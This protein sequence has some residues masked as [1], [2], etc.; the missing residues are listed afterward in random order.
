[1]R[2]RR[3]ERRRGWAELR[4]SSG[5]VCVSRGL[6]R[7]WPPAGSHAGT[8]ATLTC[9]C[10][11]P[12]LSRGRLTGVQQAGLGRGGSVARAARIFER[13]GRA[14]GHAARRTPATTA[15]V[16]T[17][18]PRAPYEG[19]FRAERG[20]GGPGKRPEN[21]K[22]A[23][24]QKKKRAHAV[25]CVAPRPGA[26]RLNRSPF[27]RQ[28]C[29]VTAPAR[30]G[31]VTRTRRRPGHHHQHTQLTRRVLLQACVP[32][33]RHQVAQLLEL[34]RLGPA[35]AHGGESACRALTVFFLRRVVRP[36][37]LSLFIHHSRPPATRPFPPP[38]PS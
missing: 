30:S 22:G 3:R 5:R 9:H 38:A 8:A 21:V 31:R 4:R 2:A 12:S 37:T 36:G 19:G 17:V 10:P 24:K 1:M 27:R 33:P 34:A 15:V 7:F 35:A 16:D 28:R 6:R 23:R 14:A 20:R 26:A 29:T 13:A 25:L 32:R 18:R 11:P